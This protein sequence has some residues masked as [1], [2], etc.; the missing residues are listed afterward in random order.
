[1]NKE[2]IVFTRTRI[3][4]TVATLLLAA[5]WTGVTG[6]TATAAKTRSV[7]PSAG[8]SCVPGG[9]PRNPA[10][11]VAAL[12]KPDSQGKYDAIFRCL[13]KY[14]TNMPGW[15]KEAKGYVYLAPDAGPLDKVFAQ[16]LMQ[17]WQGKH[18]YTRADGGYI[19]NRMFDDR[20]TWY[21]R[22]AWTQNS[23][24]DDR[25]AIFVDASP[26]PG[27]DNI[28]M[29]QPGVYLG[30]TMTDGVHPIWGPG[31][32]VTIPRGIA[33]GFFVLDFHHTAVTR[34]ECPLCTPHDQ[35]GP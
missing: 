18:W 2:R 23:L 10:K 16:A 1:M 29:V 26:V 34:S 32:K 27:I 21:H 31:S 7:S 12:R 24:L 25:P 4:A 13:G 14:R 35:E 17:L 20:Q 5:S 15:D 28:R 33:H 30:I 3:A 22:V 6:G 11:T 19:Y 8:A 9:A